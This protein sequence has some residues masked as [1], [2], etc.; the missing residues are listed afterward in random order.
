VDE[1]REGKLMKKRGS[2]GMRGGRGK[3]VIEPG[4]IILESPRIG[5]EE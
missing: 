5:L 1:H 2:E 4:Q 3:E